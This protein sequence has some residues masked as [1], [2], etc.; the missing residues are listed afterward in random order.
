M[1]GFDAARVP[2]VEPQYGGFETSTRSPSP[3]PTA[4][5]PPRPGAT[6]TVSGIPTGNSCSVS[7]AA[8]TPVSLWTWQAPVITDPVTVDFDSATTDL[9]TV[10]NTISKDWLNL[11]LTKSVTSAG[12]YYGGA[13]VTYKLVQASAAQR[14]PGGLVGWLVRDRGPA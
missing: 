9:V 13:N 12:P 1:R 6:Q 8:L 10:T 14:R 4:G 11:S 7:E 5:W 3:S 2:G